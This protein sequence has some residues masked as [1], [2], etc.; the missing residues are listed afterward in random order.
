MLG[1]A[2]LHHV[3]ESMLSSKS[4]YY[5]IIYLQSTLNFFPGKHQALKHAN[6]AAKLQ[7]VRSL[8]S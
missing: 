2:L 6:W 4:D 8:S 3:L 5:Q 7:Y 1:G